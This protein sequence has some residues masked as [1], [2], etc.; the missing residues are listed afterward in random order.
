VNASLEKAATSLKTK[1]QAVLAQPRQTNTRRRAEMA[2]SIEGRAQRELERAEVALKLAQADDL[3][4]CLRGIKNVQQLAALEQ[5]LEYGRMLAGNATGEN[6]PYVRVTDVLA[7]EYARY[8]KLGEDTKKRVAP[9]VANF[10]IGAVLAALLEFKLPPKPADPV[11]RLERQ[12]VGATIPGFFPTAKPLAARVA[13]LGGVRR[14]LFVLEPSAGSGRLAEA[15]RDAGCEDLLCIE[16]NHTLVE[17]LEVKG[18]TV[19]QGDFLEVA[20]FAYQTSESRPDVI[21]MNPPFEKGQDIDHVRHAFAQLRPGGVLVAIMSCGPF[22]RDDAKSRSFRAW[23]ET[24]D[25]DHNETLPSGTFDHSDV[26]QRTNV[27]AQLIRIRA[28]R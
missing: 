23:L 22:F 24:L 5:C 7:A 3:P 20:D 14:G 12:L 18:F 6:Y 21:L 17:L 25:V 13:E 2:A 4:Q 16:I 15:A 1:A 11:K 8:D 9:L 10:S 19:E 28:P 26:T 27:A